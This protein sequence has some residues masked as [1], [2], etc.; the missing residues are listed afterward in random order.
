MNGK[1][2]YISYLAIRD[3]QK[4]FKGTIEV[5]QDITHLRQLP[6]EQR[7]LDWDEQNTET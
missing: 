1:F 2:L 6:G 4:I 5:I 3:K 7:L